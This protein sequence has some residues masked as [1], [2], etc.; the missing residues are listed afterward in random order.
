[1][2]ARAD[3]A[4]T[5]KSPARRAWTALAFVAALFGVA[6]QPPA[7]VV[8][9]T[10]GVPAADITHTIDRNA[11]KPAPAQVKPAAHKRIG[12]APGS[13]PA[14][15]P[16]PPVCPAPTVYGICRLPF[17]QAGIDAPRSFTI[18]AQ[19]RAPPIRRI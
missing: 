4:N 17:F 8:A 15:L 14:A 9:R 18:V 1:V 12:S 2:Q 6:L 5:P 19:P 16:A 13:I 3:N 10:S 7:A 11:L